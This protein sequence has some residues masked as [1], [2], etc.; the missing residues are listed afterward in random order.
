M[1]RNPLRNMSGVSLVEVMIVLVIMSVVV[2]SIYSVNRS[3]VVRSTTEYEVTESQGG[4]RRGLNYLTRDLRVAG[5]L[6]P[7]VA[8]KSGY[9]A[10]DLTIRTASPINAFARVTNNPTATGTNTFNVASAEMSSSFK[11][12][13]SVRVIRPATLSEPDPNIFTVS[14]VAA[15][16]VELTGLTA[17]VSYKAG[18]ILV[19]TYPG[20][21]VVNEIR[22]YVDG[23]NNLLRVVNG[24]SKIVTAHVSSLLFNYQLDSDGRVKRVDITLSCTTDP[25]KQELV[26]L[27]TKTV[28]TSVLLRNV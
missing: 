7:G 18:D 21:P 4:L 16:S 5:F 27:Q 12:G 9:T 14:D 2:T 23:N 26:G 8:I 15:G 19:G 13:T 1:I 24:N 10:N 22:Y 3:V 28:R 6:V 25:G 17:G 11:D 20:A